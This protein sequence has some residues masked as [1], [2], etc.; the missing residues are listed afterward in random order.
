[1]NIGELFTHL[2]TLNQYVTGE[3]IFPLRANMKTSEIH[4]KLLDE[5]N[6]QVDP[7][8]LNKN[9]ITEYW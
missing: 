5:A 3:S 1:M 6:K 7:V 2:S 8:R 9:I 4:T